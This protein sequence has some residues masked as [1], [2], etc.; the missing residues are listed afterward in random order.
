MRKRKNAWGRTAASVMLAG[1]MLVTAAPTALAEVSQPASQA[2]QADEGDFPADA[3]HIASREDWETLARNC[4]LDSWSV[5]KTVV[6]DCDISLASSFTP[7]PT[8]GGTFYGQGH[9]ISAMDMSVDG[10]VQGL[11]RYVQESGIIE[12]LTVQCRI[13][14]GGSRNTVGGIA[15]DNAGVIESCHFM[16]LATGLSYVGGIAGTNQASGLIIGCTVQGVV[17]GAHFVGGVTGENKGVVRDCVNHASV[18]TK[19]S[20]NQ[21]D[22]SDVTLESI[23]KTEKGTTVTNLGGIA[24]TSSG[25]IRGCTN[26]GPV[27]YQHVGYNVGGIAG[28]QTGYIEGC[29]NYGTVQGRK[30]AGGIVGQMEPQTV[31]KYG[32]DTLQRVQS[33]MNTLKSQI[34]KMTDDAKDAYNRKIDDLQYN[35][36]KAN[37]A[38]DKVKTYETTGEEI[39]DDAKDL[40][41][42]VLHSGS[43]RNARDVLRDRAD[44]QINEANDR[45]NDA[46]NSAQEFSSSITNQTELGNITDDMRAINNQLNAIS[47]TITGTADRIRNHD[48]YSDISDRDTDADTAAKVTNCVNYAKVDADRNAGGIAGAMAFENDL[49]PED[50]IQDTIGTES[51]NATVNTRC[52][53]SNCINQGQVT[54]KKDSVGGIAGM[55]RTGLLKNCQNYGP[56]QAPDVTC[57]GGIVGT[58]QSNVRASAAKCLI[59]GDSNVGGIAGKGYTITDCRTMVH[60]ESDG[61]YI[62][63]IAGQIADD[64]DEDSKLADLRDTK[65]TVTGNCFVENDDLFGIDGVSYE[66]TAWGVS[67]EELMQM[68]NVPEA[69]GHLTVQF[70]VDGTQVS[71]RSVEYGGSLL[72]ADIPEL[73]VREHA[74][75]KWSDFVKENIT[76][77]QIVEAVYNT[78]N[79]VLA[80]AQKIGDKPQVLAVGYF[81]PEQSLKLT[82]LA[83]APQ[84]EGAELITAMSVEVT[85][86]DSVSREIRYCVGDGN[87]KRDTVWL[88]HTDGWQ[89]VDSQLDG[90]YLVFTMPEG[91]T[92]FA[93]LRLPMDLRLPA[94]IAAA[95]A[96]LLLVLIVHIRRKKRKARKAAK[97]AAAAGAESKE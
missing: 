34:D 85:N 35:I 12:N 61:E 68:E 56:V 90:S 78:A 75:G 46:L 1:V 37:D 22:L 20:E 26:R 63:A 23:I 65:S 74:E 77:D 11:F 79:T 27:G 47:T 16:G 73:P 86:A 31:L 42:D 33:Q 8:F 21:I 70:M 29:A 19:E 43:L 5:G 58:S 25:V 81:K 24:G 89:K 36:D 66:G 55:Q 4:R 72:D 92:D 9:T 87:A 52:V 2:Q 83:D 94:A 48:W 6:L 45:L 57:V 17:Y 82:D 28:D 15:A 64:L 50:D 95:V 76:E 13:A 62:G 51:M 91:E 69:F 49:D 71:V 54:G 39:R 60:I 18:N 96:A 93:V 44:A 84:V 67:Y 32:V 59:E 38:M 88:R 80:S 53:L 7:I 30:E 10:S 3:V 41:S 97:A 14:P 40:A